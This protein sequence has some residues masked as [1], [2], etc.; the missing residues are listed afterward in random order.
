MIAVALEKQV[1]TLLQKCS[2][3]IFSYCALDIPTKDQ[4][5]ANMHHNKLMCTIQQDH[6]CKHPKNSLQ[7]N[8]QSLYLFHKHHMDVFPQTNFT[9]TSIICKYC[10]VYLRMIVT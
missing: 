5:P 1:H 3:S 7:K 6:L 10:P 2:L 4:G 9:D 8:R